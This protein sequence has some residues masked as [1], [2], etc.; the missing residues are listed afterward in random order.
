[1]LIFIF[2]LFAERA[3][4]TIIPQWQWAHLAYRRAFLRIILQCKEP[5]FLGEMADSGTGTEQV[6]DEP[7]IGWPV[8]PF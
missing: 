5:V 7:G 8:V 3:L 6:Q 4:K 2:P 1:M